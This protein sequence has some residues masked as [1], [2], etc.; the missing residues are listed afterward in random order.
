MNKKAMAFLQDMLRQTLAKLPSLEPVCDDGLFPAFTKVY[1]ADSTGF[2]LP[3]DLH[4]TFPGAGGSAATAGAKIQAVWDDKSRLFSH[5]ALT[6]GNI[7]EQRSIA[8]VVALAQKG[9]RFIFD[10]GYCKLNALASIATAGAYCFCRL[11]HPTNICQ[12]VAGRLCPMKLAEFLTT[13]EHD[14]PLLEK[15]IS[16]GATERVAARLMAVR[17]PEAIVNKRRRIARKN[18]SKKGYTPSQAHLTLMAW[19]LFMTHVPPTIGNTATIV[20]VYPLRWQI[21]RIF[22]SW[23]SS[24]H[25]AS[26]T[27]HKEDSTLCDL[28]GRMLLIWFNNALCPQM[29][30]TLW[31]KQKRERSL[32][33]LVQHFQALAARWMQAIFQS[34]LELHRFLQRACAAASRLAAKASRKRR[35]TAQILQEDFRHPLESVASAAAISA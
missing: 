19:H 18:A 13:V 31:L 2:E 34:E 4:K 27:T 6:P 7:P 14:R 10:L 16:L 35:T 26:I 20:K 32:L 33:K 24:L 23:K 9:M 3:H 29:R 5:W 11:N 12:T 30:A 25:V 21:E 15:S 8:Q 22:K 1:I 17:R 28:Y